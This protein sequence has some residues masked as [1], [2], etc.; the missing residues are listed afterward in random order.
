MVFFSQFRRE[1]T[2]FFNFILRLFLEVPLCLLWCRWDV[3]HS[4][5]HWSALRRWDLLFLWMLHWSTRAFRDSFPV[6]FGMGSVCLQANGFPSF[7]MLR[8][9]GGRCCLY[10]RD[11]DPGV[12]GGVHHTCGCLSPMTSERLKTCSSVLEQFWTRFI[13]N[14]IGFRTVCTQ[15]EM[16]CAWRGRQAGMWLLFTLV[17]CILL[18]HW[19][20]DASALRILLNCHCRAF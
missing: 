19:W 17:V 6:F 4:P 1:K 12:Y 18:C 7:V 20:L 9:L 10:L 13:R 5:F 15:S 14:T 2:T 3:L 16:V 11:W 8:N